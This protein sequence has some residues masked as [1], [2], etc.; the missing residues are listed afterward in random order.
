ME[1]TTKLSASPE[2]V[3]HRLF[4]TRAGE[5]LTNTASSRAFAMLTCRL[6]FRLNPIAQLEHRSF[7][8]P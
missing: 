7:C 2:P 3:L 1:S 5:V 4:C 8:Q 6:K